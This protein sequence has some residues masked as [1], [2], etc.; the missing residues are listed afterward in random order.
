MDKVLT[1][2]LGGGRGTRLHPLTKNRSKPAVPI[3]G[4]YRL[5]DV[6]IS[7]CINSKLYKIFVLTQFNSASL[8]RHISQSYKFDVFRGGFVEVLAAEQTTSRSDWYQGT[9]DAIRA[10]LRH[11][12]NLHFDYYLILAG[13]HLYRMNYEPFIKFHIENNADI[14]IAAYPIEPKD[15]SQFGV[16]KIDQNNKVTDFVEKPKTPELIEK[17]KIN[18]PTTSKSLL[19]SMGIYVFSKNVFHKIIAEN[20]YSDFGKDLIPN[21]LKSHKVVSYP[22]EGY[23]QDIGTIKAFYEANVQLG[24]ENP[25]FSFFSEQGNIYTHARFLPGSRI[26]DCYIKESIISSGCIINHAKIENSII[27]VRS[28]V[29]GDAELNGVVLMGADL[30]EKANQINSCKAKNIPRIGIGKNTKIMNAIIDKNARIGENV[31]IRNENRVE[32]F[33][34]QGYSIRDGIVVIEKSAIVPNGTII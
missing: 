25:K 13:D 19:A 17:M 27:G 30:Y 9:A 33:D 20:N 31:I 23:W 14:S 3:G 21:S 24:F 32:N 6:P 11:F 15:A 28:I 12:A 7:N 8:N 22:F 4:N 10:N 2:I 1:I 18:D 16:L 29:E 26:N 34:G 5:I